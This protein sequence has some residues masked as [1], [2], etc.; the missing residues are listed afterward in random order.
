[1]TFAE[2]IRKTRT[3]KKSEVRER[4]REET[5]IDKL[6]VDGTKNLIVFIHSIGVR[7]FVVVSCTDN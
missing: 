3:R 6:T 5:A 7:M 2:K 4:E 1:M